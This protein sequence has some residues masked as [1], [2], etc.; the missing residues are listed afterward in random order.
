M[1]RPEPA[2]RTMSLHEWHVVG[3]DG[4]PVLHRTVHVLRAL[5]PGLASYPFRFDRREAEAEVRT[6]RGARAGTPYVDGDGLTVVDLDFLRPL[7]VGETASLEYETR[8]AWKTVPPPQ[9]RRATRLRVERLDMR[10]EFDPRRLPLDLQ[11]GV[12]DGYGA[13]APLRAAERVELDHDGAAHRFVD[14]LQGGTVGFFWTWP[15]GLEPGLP[16]VEE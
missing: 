1:D 4:L 9:V 13:D 6:I 12:W 2:Y 15:P 7:A 16:A 8:F 14:E 11:W 3:A 10:V 5:R